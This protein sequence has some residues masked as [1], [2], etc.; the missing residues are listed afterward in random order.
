MRFLRCVGVFTFAALAISIL[1]QTTEAQQRLRLAS[2]FAKPDNS[3]RASQVGYIPRH[4]RQ[5]A[6]VPEAL[7][8]E[9]MPAESISSHGDCTS[10]G[11]SIGAPVDEVIGG[12]C[13]NCFSDP[14]V[15]DCGWCGGCGDCRR[16]WLDGFGGI[17]Q[18]SEYFIGAHGFRAYNSGRNTAFVDDSS[19]G[20]HAGINAGLPLTWLTC[21]LASGQIGISTNHSQLTEQL[22]GDSR[23]QLFVTAG[24]FR[25]VD[26]GLQG[27]VVADFLFENWDISS[28]LI[29][30]RSELSWAFPGQ[31]AFGFQYTDGVH[32]NSDP[33]NPF[34][35]TEILNTYRFF[36]RRPVG[37]GG[38]GEV[39]GGFTEFHGM[40]GADVTLPICE[41]VFLRS[42]TTYLIP[43]DTANDGWNISMS[44]VF[45]PR[46]RGWYNTYHTPMFNV[47]DNG[48][49]IIRR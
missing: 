28:D 27:G 43:G 47:A 33:N 36:F 26:H 34:F 46:G 30:L 16:C 49:M 44:L 29:Q 6:G 41:R 2:R 19:F 8:V 12:D 25:R 42:S 1:S 3:R 35:D 37:D 21:G 32:V 24:L 9:P 23:E 14:C 48:S 4:L 40:F 38:M 39:F 15:D 11:D 22:R 10:C 20:F 7:T 5:E 17:L 45:R 13:G 18:N 31:A